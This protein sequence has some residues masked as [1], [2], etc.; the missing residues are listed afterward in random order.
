M[1]LEDLTIESPLRELGKGDEGIVFTDEKWVYKLFYDITDR[2]WSFLNEKSGCFSKCKALSKIECF[3]FK[4]QRYIR[5]PYLDFEPLGN[6]DK[7]EIISF[8]KFCKLNGIMFA[9]IKPLNFIQTKS[10][11]NLIDYGRSFIKYSD[12]ELLNATKRAYLL[13]KFPTMENNKFKKFTQR[14]NDD[15][16]FPEINGWEIFWNEVK[17]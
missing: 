10:G 14:I 6:F 12:G 16:E 11:I 8:L 1:K 5:Y 2:E 7:N 4:N 17:N 13:W 9:N 3:E 15:E